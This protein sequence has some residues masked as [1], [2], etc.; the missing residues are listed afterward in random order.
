MV[1]AILRIICR[2]REESE[3]G[4]ISGRHANEK[5]LDIEDIAGKLAAAMK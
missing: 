2:N 5:S 3:R 1:Q 4:K